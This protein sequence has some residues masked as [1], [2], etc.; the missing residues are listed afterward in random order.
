MAIVYIL[1]CADGALYVGHT[2]DLKDRL[3][4]H[5]QGIACLFTARR[6]PVVV[7]YREEFPMLALAL[8]RERQIKKWTRRKKEALI[9]GDRLLLKR[10]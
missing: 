5:N 8:A 6:R 9:A 3:R 2:T 7:V 1:R 4:R 10:L